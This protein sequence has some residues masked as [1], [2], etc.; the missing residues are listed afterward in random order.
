MNSK[1]VNLK[2]YRSISGTL[3]RISMNV[4]SPHSSSASWSN[5]I[6]KLLKITHSKLP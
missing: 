5:C 1:K 3:Y 2:L 6:R 4:I